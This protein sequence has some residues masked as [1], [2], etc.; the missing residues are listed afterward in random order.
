MNGINVSKLLQKVNNTYKNFKVT[1]YIF[2]EEIQC[3]LI[4]LTHLPTDAKIMHIANDDIENLF[5]LSFQTIP[6]SSNG[7]PH[8]LEHTVLCGSE[9]FPVKDPFFSMIKRSLNTFMNA[10]TGS[11]YTCYPA[12][13]EIE[14]DFY[15]LL[16]VYSDCVFHPKLT[17]LSFLQEGHR[18]EYSTLNDP[19]TPLQIKGIVYNEMKGSLNSPDD[20]LWHTML[21]KLTPDLPYAFN[22]GGDP[23]N[24]FELTYEELLNFHKK[25]YHP[26]HCLFFFYGN[27]PTEKHLDFLEEKVLKDVKKAYPLPGLKTQKRFSSPIN[28]T[29]Y[30]PVA[31]GED[32]SQSDKDLIAFGFLTCPITNQKEVLSLILLD[33]ILTETDAS[34]LKYSLLKSGLCNQVDSIMDTDMTEIPWII[35]CRGAEDKNKEKLFEVITKTLKKIVKEKISK[36]MIEA[37]MHQMEFSRS[38]ITGGSS[39]YGLTLF[40]RAALAKQ[41]G[42]QAEDELKIHSLFD[43]IRKEME[44]PNYLTDLIE[45]YLINNTHLVKLSLRPDPD[46]EKKESQFEKSMLAEIEKTLSEK[47]KR[48]IIDEALELQKY[49]LEQEH[50]SIECLPKI[51]IEE[52]PPKLKY[53]PLSSEKMGDITIYHHDC[54][55]N[56]ILN[57]DL[58]INLPEIAEEDL[59]SLPLFAHL[60]SEIGSTKRD[61]K[62]NLEFI[63]LYL[64][65]FSSFISINTLAENSSTCA[66]AIFLRAKALYRNSEKLFSIL[67]EMTTSADFSDKERIKELVLQQ[68]TILDQTINQAA[69]SYA[70]NE[71]LSSFTL[72][73]YIN[74]MF[75][76]L[77]YFET[78]KQLAEN[79]DKNIDALIDKLK[80]L[81]KKIL[82]VSHPDLVISCDKS[83]YKTLKEN[84]FFS[85]TDLKLQLPPSWNN[86]I[87]Y[88]K[89]TESEGKIIA[90]PVAFTS[91][92]YTTV[93]FT[94]ADSPYLFLATSILE[95]KVLHKNIRE[96]GG[97]YGSGATYNP[98]SG[99]FYFYS[100]R[101]P[102]LSETIDSFIFSINEI[103]QGKFDTEDLIA[104]KLQAIQD[105]D[106]PVAPGKRAATTYHFEKAHKTKALREKYREDILKA[107]KRSVQ[108]AVQ[109]HLQK[110]ID[111]PKI[112]S[113]CNKDFFDRENSKLK[114]PL[115]IQSI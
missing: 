104:A 4:E 50:Q 62:Q 57:V 54:F 99:S 97:A 17:K 76:G 1:K 65:S 86:S 2:I 95:N 56:K 110:Q 88:P 80:S 111:K 45:K 79:L 13:S 47:D 69:M 39:P 83:F 53:F 24:I 66:P 85:L 31:K 82:N 61:Y 43:T 107:D 93:N 26:S 7:A 33:S 102:H 51:E 52:I 115:T 27:I 58:V 84:K 37:A 12:S 20:R 18:L 25:Y 59:S 113:F 77:P 98:S 15:N 42:C 81:Q 112:V 103:S 108:L 28:H 73:S 75:Y 5:C 91:A 114:N 105:L 72:P 106:S 67:K 41:Q 63:N 71:S 22:S 38:E 90:S 21:E 30:Y 29:S 96:K 94:H 89:S 87:K 101:D 44:N 109:K 64:G 60:L 100:Y 8:I 9:K 55:T 19:T 78:I 34:P 46:L 23:K 35:V 6:S 36:E 74:N 68:Y 32:L 40:M 92:G 14:K 49:Q 16:N 3:S 11:D 10:F 48:K 70:I